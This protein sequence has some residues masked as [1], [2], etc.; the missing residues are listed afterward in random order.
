M[1][2]KNSRNRAARRFDRGRIRNCV[3]GSGEEQE[4]CQ[5]YDILASHRA[6]GKSNAVASI[7]LSVFTV[8]QEDDLW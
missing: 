7:L 2:G 6:L 5:E 3:D 4:A 8:A 1:K